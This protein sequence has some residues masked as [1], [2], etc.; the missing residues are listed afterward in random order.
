MATQALTL[1][2]P[3]SLLARIR[4]RARRA[5]RTVEAEVLDL[6]SAAVPTDAAPPSGHPESPPTAGKG[7]RTRP[8]DRAASDGK[9]GRDGARSPA[10]PKAAR[11][12]DE[13]ALPQDIA[14]AIA[15]IESLDDRALREAMKPLMTARQAKRLADLNRKA[16]DQGLTAAERVEQS[17]LLHIYDKSMVVR[18]AAM[19]ELHKRGVDVA[20]LIAK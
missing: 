14:D 6:L 9:R 1:E 16:Q 20:E 3:D 7:P 2:L 13:E 15:R 11:S 8:A 17:E 19:A 10:R 4:D 5:D 18:A 12:K